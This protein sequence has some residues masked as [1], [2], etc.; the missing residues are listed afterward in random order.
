MAD[1][2]AP[3]KGPSIHA[4]AWSCTAVV[5]IPM[6]LVRIVRRS[7]VG[8]VAEP[9]S[10]SFVES[11]CHLALSLRSE[12]A[13]RACADHVGHVRTEVN[14]CRVRPQLFRPQLFLPSSADFSSSTTFSVHNLFR[15]QL[16]PSTT[17]SVHNFFRPQL[18]VHNVF[19][20]ATQY[21][22][23]N[24]IRPQLNPQLS[25]SFVFVFFSLPQ[26]F[27]QRTEPGFKGGRM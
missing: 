4:C 8:S 22:V 27:A 21:S 18:L 25:F 3:P 6:R 10:Y 26:P 14:Q 1:G 23:H 24:L 19:P 7:R 13:L 20:S 12:L 5:S 17:F 11:I 15:P 2:P 16:V 9:R